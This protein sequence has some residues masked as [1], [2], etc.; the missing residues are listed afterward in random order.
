MDPRLR[1]A[2]AAFV[3]SAALGG[4]LN[5]SGLVNV[6]IAALL[7]SISGIALVYIVW[8]FISDLKSGVHGGNAVVFRALA[9]WPGWK[10]GQHQ[11]AAEHFG[12]VLAAAT[13]A[14]LIVLFVWTSYP[15]PWRGW[16]QAANDPTPSTGCD[17]N[18]PTMEPLNET[19]IISAG[20]QGIQLTHAGRTRALSIGNCDSLVLERSADGIRINAV[21]YDANGNKLGNITDNGYEIERDGLVVEHTG[22]LSTLVVHNNSREELLYVKYLN[23]RAI[24]VRGIF[25]CPSAPNVRVV[26]TDERFQVGSLSLAGCFT[27][28]G[29]LCLFCQ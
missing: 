3:F 10:F 25:Y 21:I 22:D 13:S 17:A 6:P 14:V 5:M 4:G 7:F 15:A 8:T 9:Q 27:D 19:A 24:K 18:S 12:S 20:H 11:I 26:I 16:L 29:G 1:L 28:S 23:R 2:I